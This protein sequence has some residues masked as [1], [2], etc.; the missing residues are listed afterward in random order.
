ML[1]GSAV[2]FTDFPARTAITGSLGCK[3]PLGL[4]VMV[5]SARI[6]RSVS[7]PR[8]G[9]QIPSGGWI[10]ILP[11]WAFLLLLIRLIILLSY[12][13]NH[14]YTS[15][16]TQLEKRPQGLYP[17]IAKG[18]RQI[19]PRSMFLFIGVSLLAGMIGFI[20]EEWKNLK[21][22]D[23]MASS[24]F[25]SLSA[26]TTPDTWALPLFCIIYFMSVSVSSIFKVL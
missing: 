12:G 11:Q 5:S 25:G 14:S 15:K 3:R 2:G 4:T 16:P 26:S 7:Q 17:G 9:A 23:G 20:L 24:K 10:I 18:Y 13:P 19:F 6:S 1:W 22:V 21:G 8:C